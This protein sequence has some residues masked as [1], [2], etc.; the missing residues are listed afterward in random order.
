MAAEAGGCFRVLLCLWAYSLGCT[1]ENRAAM[2][3]LRYLAGRRMG[4]KTQEGH[5]SDLGP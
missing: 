3:D 2:Y 5:I 4:L 1:S